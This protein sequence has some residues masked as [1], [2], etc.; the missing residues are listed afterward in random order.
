MYIYIEYVY[1]ITVLILFDLY[2]LM[3]QSTRIVTDIPG[4]TDAT[5]GNSTQIST[6]QHL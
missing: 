5:F 1:M 3:V 2:L 6:D 4:T